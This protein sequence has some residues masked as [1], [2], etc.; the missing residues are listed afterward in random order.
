MRT[1]LDSAA[2]DLRTPLNRLQATAEGGDER[3]RAGIS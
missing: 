3:T 1:V 2:H